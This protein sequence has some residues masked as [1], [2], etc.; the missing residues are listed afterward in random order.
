MNYHLWKLGCQYNEWEAERLHFLMRDFGFVESG[1]EDADVIIILACSV[2]QTAIDRILGKINNWTKTHTDFFH[3]NGTETSKSNKTILLTGCIL[4][5]DKKKFREK[6]LK[7]FKSGDFETLKYFIS[8][9]FELGFKSKKILKPAYRRG[10]QVQDDTRINT[11]N[12]I[13]KIHDNNLTMKQFNNATI[14]ILFVAFGAP[15][16]EFWINENLNKI[17]VKIAIGVGGAF[18]HISGKVPRAPLIIRRLGM[19][20]LFRLIV[21]PWRFKRQLALIEFIW[22]VL[23]ERLRKS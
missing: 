16:Q 6:G 2:R 1:P 17:P 23:K 13:S 8:S 21:Q 10:R 5:S 12:R 19:E 3:R 18:D 7:Y 14:D 22:L 15:K 11:N 9:H 4:D 20:W